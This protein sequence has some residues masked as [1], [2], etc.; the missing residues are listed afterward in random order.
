MKTH[1]TTFTPEL[2]HVQKPDAN[3]LRV[4]L[5]IVQAQANQEV[6]E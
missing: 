5:D 3:I 2:F 6:V 4:T 1:S